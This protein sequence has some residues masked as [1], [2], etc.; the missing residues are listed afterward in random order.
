MRTTVAELIE[1]L[2]LC[3]PDSLVLFQ[4]G[5]DDKGQ[6]F[7]RNSVERIDKTHSTTTIVIGKTS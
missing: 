5:V 3:K 7:G 4:T 6:A 1:E 2:R